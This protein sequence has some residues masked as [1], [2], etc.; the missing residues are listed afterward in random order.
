MNSH[1][2]WFALRWQAASCERAL[3]GFPNRLPQTLHARPCLPI[4]LWK[5]CSCYCDMITRFKEQ[6]MCTEC[7]LQHSR[8]LKFFLTCSE[9]DELRVGWR[10]RLRERACL[11][12]VVQ[13]WKIKIS[14]DWSWHCFL[15]RI[16][17]YMHW[18]QSST[19]MTDLYLQNLN[20][21]DSSGPPAKNCEI[22]LP[23]AKSN[24]VHSFIGT[25][26]ES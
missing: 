7:I 21:M 10:R 6:D 11:D 5:I 25:K 24:Y 2:F 14:C 19:S 18:R 17:V 16:G 9:D 4:E 15:F 20:L 12:D 8:V 3:P 1:L 13:S 26:C 23:P 22:P